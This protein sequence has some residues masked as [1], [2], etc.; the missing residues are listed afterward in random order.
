VT[1]GLETIVDQL[2][3]QLGVAACFDLLQKP[4]LE[5]FIVQG[6]ADASPRQA[7]GIFARFPVDVRLRAR[8]VSRQFCGTSFAER[9][10]ARPTNQFWLP[11]FD[12]S[13]EKRLRIWTIIIKF[14]LMQDSNAP[15]GYQ[16]SWWEYAWNRRLQDEFDMVT[17][18]ACLRVSKEFNVRLRRS[19]PF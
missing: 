8:A 6:M 5:H 1:I 14:A 4:G 19:S 3:A 7:R 18:G 10:M 16:R 9:S 17:G 13:E 11:M 2:R 15:N 12:M